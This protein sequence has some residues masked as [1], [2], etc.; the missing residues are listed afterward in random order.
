M[1]ALLE[2]IKNPG[3][4][5]K[6]SPGEL[7]RLSLEI[8][9]YII[10][11]L[12]SVGGHFASNLGVVELTVALHYVLNTP[13]DK[14]IWD[15][16]HQTY[17]H[18]IL[19]GR[20]DLLKQV[21]MFGGISGFPKREESEYDLYNTGHAGTSISQMLGE[22][23]ARDALGKD[24][25][26][27]SVIGDASIASG[28][29]FE[30]L[31]HGGHLKTD[32]LVILNDNDM[33]I[34]KNVGALNQ[35]LNR[36]ITS[37][38][39]N[40]WKK[41]WYNFLMWLPLIGPV[42]MLFSKKLERFTKDFL[43]PGSLFSDF[44]FR[45][46]G[47]VDGHDVQELVNV[48]EK[49]VNMK[50]PILMHVYTQKGK[51]Y[52][53]AENDPVLYH[54][55]GL[56]NPED[57]VNSNTAVSD[58]VS[59]SDIVGESL[60]EIY[61]SNPKIAAITPAMIE[62]SGLRS[63]YDAHPENV[64][65]AG[66]AE[67]HAVAF[68]GALASGGLLPYLCIYSTFLTRGLDQLVED[69]AL[70]NLPVRLV[71]DRA[72]CVG[73]DGETHQGLMDLGH[74][75]SIPNISIYAPSNGAQLKAYIHYVSGDLTGPTAVRF[76]KSF[77]DRHLLEAPLP[78][79]TSH[80]PEVIGKGSDLAIVCIGIMLSSGLKTAEIIESKSN[81]EA[82]VIGIQWI[83]PMPFETMNEILSSYREIIFIEESYINASASSYIL[84]NLSPENRARVRKIYA[85]P[86]ES[87]PHGDRAAILNEYG[88]SP[89]AIADSFLREISSEK[90]SSKTF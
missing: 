65:D 11:T 88:L 55:V 68:A 45:Y 71:I 24:Y 30:A 1:K 72:G 81:L 87:I 89:L 62:G 83:K 40:K 31:N 75:L 70:M 43:T 28:M 47:P 5:K 16:G 39:Y 12:A 54:S 6:L 18:K 15:V 33:S 38:I 74:L 77:E 69:I 25:R 46:I 19:T 73:P 8:R 9:E 86:Q 37:P 2:N 61:K 35:Y 85:F 3:D 27:V 14:L 80:E 4:L 17:P 13:V 23:V 10:Q 42:M 26:C 48:L 76:P 59:F 29:A 51:G 56:F 50:G 41:F 82:S 22:A 52:T 7:P 57:G 67:Q 66:I 58:R 36:L 34:S 44:G 20:K 32:S 63:F 60:C 49:A 21:R 84:L 78:D 90:F 53:H 64:F 79:I